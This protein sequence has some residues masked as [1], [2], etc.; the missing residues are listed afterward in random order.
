M[1]DIYDLFNQNIF[2]FQT[3]A[4]VVQVVETRNVA[5]PASEPTP[6]A[7]TETVII[8]DPGLPTRQISST[9]TPPRRNLYTT[10][11]T[12]SPANVTPCTTF[13]PASANTPLFMFL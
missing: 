1:V 8:G 3:P 6:T 13:T 2:F 4:K 10:G 11:S 12:A 5:H 7:P 9:E